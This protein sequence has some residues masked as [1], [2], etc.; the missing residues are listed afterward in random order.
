M[1]L[2]S[3]F[4]REQWDAEPISFGDV[5]ALA[6]DAT[7]PNDVV[8]SVVWEGPNGSCL[9]QTSAL[10]SFRDELAAAIVAEVNCTSMNL[11][12]DS[13]TVLESSAKGMAPFDAIALA[14]PSIGLFEHL[15][16][17]LRSH[18]YLVVPAYRS[19]FNGGMTGKD[20][21]HQ[22]GRKDGWRVQVYRWDRVE[23]KAPSWP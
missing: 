22:M 9:F 15:S 1:S 20:F 23:K 11:S 12:L 16:E 5:D 18:V 19:E 4:K 3:Q 7:M 21:R 13:V 8:R 14:P 2:L 10:N 6:Y 17:D